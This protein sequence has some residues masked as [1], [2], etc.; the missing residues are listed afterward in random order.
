MN[1]FVPRR[2]TDEQRE[3]LDRFETLSD[4][5]TYRRD[6]GFF[7]KLRSALPLSS[8]AASPS[9]VPTL[10]PSEARAVMLELFPEGFEEIE[11]G[12][13]RARGVHERGRRG[14]DLAGLRR[15]AGDEVEHGWE[16][17]WRQFHRPVRVGSL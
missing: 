15:C 11:A 4:E 10:G 12:W 17:R 1:V 7:E 9:T 2:L 6:E 5:D 13:A 3:L 8:C 16:D 14:S